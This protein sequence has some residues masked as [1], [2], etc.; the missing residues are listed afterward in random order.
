MFYYYF[1]HTC[2]YI[3][4]SLTN[5]PMPDLLQQVRKLVAE[6]IPTSLRGTVWPL[7]IGN[8][9]QVTPALYE[10]SRR[11]GQRVRRLAAER[12]AADQHREAAANARAANAAASA[13]VADP[14]TCTE[15]AAAAAA[16]AEEAAAVAAAAADAATLTVDLSSD[17]SAAAAAGT[18]TGGALG[19]PAACHIGVDDNNSSTGGG[20]TT[21][22]DS[23]HPLDE[24][25]TPNSCDTADT[26]T[27]EVNRDDGVQIEGM[28]GT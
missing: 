14:A 25:D 20:G 13:A 24:P 16:E 11:E 22:V 28:Y 7:L 21:I 19:A 15:A 23:K 3:Y 10:E 2:A 18:G 27:I 9:A 6:G 26:D 4:N 1:V 17:D 12:E 5:L 8:K